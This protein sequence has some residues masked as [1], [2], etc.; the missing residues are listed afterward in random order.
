LDTYGQEGEADVAILP[1]P[2]A[3]ADAIAW[4]GHPDVDRAWKNRR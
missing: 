2:N 4:Q 1:A 3:A